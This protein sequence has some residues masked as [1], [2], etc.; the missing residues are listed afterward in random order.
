MVAG[1]S[2]SSIRGVRAIHID[3]FRQG[4]NLRGGL[5]LDLGVG[6]PGAAVK[7]IFTL[8]EDTRQKIE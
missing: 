1:G 4:V 5:L 6:M 8:T 3:T 2:R 7:R